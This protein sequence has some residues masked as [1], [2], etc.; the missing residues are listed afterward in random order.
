MPTLKSLPKCPSF[1]PNCP[2]TAILSIKICICQKKV[3]ILHAKSCN[4]QNNHM[5]RHYM[6]PIVDRTEMAP[7]QM[8][9]SSGGGS[10]FKAEIGEYGTNTGGGFIQE[11]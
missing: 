6:R 4:K 11:P 5:K 3:V 7:G 10:G 8:L 1:V 2:L 9:C